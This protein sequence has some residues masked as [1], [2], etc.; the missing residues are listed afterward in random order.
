[1][2]HADELGLRDSFRTLGVI[3][4]DDL[5]GLMVNSIALL[6]PSRAEGWSTSVEEAKSLGKRVILSNIPV[7]LEQAPPDGIYVDP[8]D[9][10]GLADAMYEARS[11]FDP[12]VES[13]RSARA[14]HELPRRVLAFGRAYQD[15]VLD[16]LEPR[17][18]LAG[19]RPGE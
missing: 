16:A 17:L 12:L 8:D 4:Y 3:P 2:A 18:S 13:E 5:L 10:P 14:R 7:H 11:T 15:I 9:A 19:H 1:M 6:N